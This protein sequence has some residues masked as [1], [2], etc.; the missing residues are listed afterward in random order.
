MYSMIEKKNQFMDRYFTTTM[1]GIG[2]FC[3][4]LCHF[5]G[6]F[7]KGITLFTPL[8]GIGVSLFLIMSGYGLSESWKVRGG[9]NWWRKRLVAVIIPYI[10][11]E[12][13]GYWWF[14]KISIC[15]MLLDALCIKPLYHNGWYF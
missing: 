13:I 7:G 9:K 11:V 14:Y 6:T 15:E 1:K 10:F 5:M 8:G 2:I 3:V 12:L 4:M